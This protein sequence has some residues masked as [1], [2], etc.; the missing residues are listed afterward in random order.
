[1]RTQHFGRGF[2]ALWFCNVVAV[3][4]SLAALCGAAASSDLSG[5]SG[6]TVLRISQHPSD[7]AGT[8]FDAHAEAWLRYGAAEGDVFL[9]RPD[10]YLLASWAQP[11]AGTLQAALAPFRRHGPEPMMSIR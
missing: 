1:M 10:G 3:S 9:V 7:D 4:D 8:L 2:V 11:Q 5:L 6:L